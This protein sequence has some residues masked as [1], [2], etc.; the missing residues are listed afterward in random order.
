[1]KIEQNNK[2]KDL[3]IISPEVFNDV[4]G[5][6]MEVC[7]QDKLREAGID[8]NFVQF[9]Q[10]QS[11]K[12]VVRGLHFQWDQPLGKLIR[13]TKG[14][15]YVVAADIRKKSDTFKQWVGM[16]LSEE[17]KKLLY[18]PAGFAAGFCAL[19]DLTDVQYSYTVLYNS[20]GESNIIWNDPDIGI[21]WPIKDPI[22]SDRDKNAQT[23]KQWIERPELNLF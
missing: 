12:G 8:A 1:M 2:I 3:Y 20:K 19:S 4:R 9:N 18:V 22:L 23:L 10:S 15:A 6:F 11:K 5:F 13:V 7:R 21:D 16:E 17:N 14:S